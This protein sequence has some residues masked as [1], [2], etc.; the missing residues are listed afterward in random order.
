MR[1][2][3]A[4]PISERVRKTCEDIQGM[5]KKSNTPLKLVE[6][7][8]LHVTLR[9]LGNV[10]NET[11]EKVKEIM[12]KIEFNS[13]KARTTMVG[14]FPS[15]SYIHVVW[16]GVD[17]ETILKIHEFIESRLARLGFDKDSQYLPHITLARVKGKP[18]KKLLEIVGYKTDMEFEIKYVTL[19]KSTLTK[20]GPLYETLYKKYLE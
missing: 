16:L 10:N 3:L 8:N 20:E 13:F 7:K 6:P 2:F 17:G 11:I 18:T 19:V 12:D 14:V 1:A 9:F 4:L 5:I 15:T